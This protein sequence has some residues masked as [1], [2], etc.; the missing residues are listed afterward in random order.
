[1]IYKPDSPKPFRASLQSQAI[2]FPAAVENL[3][4]GRLSEAQAIFRDI[5]SADARHY[6]S[7]HHLGLIEHRIGQNERALDFIR[8][9]LAIKP[10]YAEALSDM[11]LI[12]AQLD[13]NEEAIAA[14]ERAIAANPDY[15]EAH[16]TLGNILLRQGRLAD[17]R[18][19][20]VRAVEL[21]PS[22]AAAYAS[23]ADTLAA[24]G[25][26]EEALLAC[27]RAISLDPRLAI[28]HG[29]KGSILHRR[30]KFAEAA[31]A[32]KRALQINPNFAV[33]HTR[34]ANALRTAGRFEAA[35]TAN[36]RAI[37]LDPAGAE[38]YVN[39]ALT[40]QALGRHVEGQAAYRKAI[41]LKPGYVEAHSG[42]GLLLH[43]IGHTEDAIKAFQAA[44]AID[45]ECDF[46]LTNLASLFKDLGRTGE[47]VAAYRQLLTGKGHVPAASLYD[48]CALR[49]Q[50]CDWEGL[51]TGETKAMETLTRDGERVPPFASLAMQCSPAGHLAL[52]R[53]WARGFAVKPGAGAAQTEPRAAINPE[54]RIRIGYLSSGFCSH[55]TAGLIA[56][57]IERHDRKR[58]EV[59]AYCWSHDDGSDMRQRLTGAFDSFADIRQ[60]SQADSARRIRDDGI[61][62]LIDLKGYTPDARTLILANRP[63]PVQVNFL[64]YPGTMGARFIDYIIADPFVAPMV[65][66]PYF[67]EKIVHLPDCYQ[68]CDTKR[69][70][71]GQPERTGCGL[72]EDGFVFCC[73]G[74][75]SKITGAVFAIWMRLL[76][77]TAGSVL[78]LLDCGETAAANLRREASAHGIG[79]ERLV[80]AQKLPMEE[81][82]A[83]YRLAD[84]LLDTWPFSASASAAEALWCGLPVLTCAGEMFAGRVAGSLLNAARLPELVTSSPADYEALGLRLAS[85]GLMLDEIRDKLAH[86]RTVAPLFAIERYARNIEAAYAHMIWL[87]A[88]G[89]PPE[90]FAVAGLPSAGGAG[91]RGDSLRSSAVR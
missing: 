37:E 62:I 32:Y 47:A 76:E 41:S 45:P 53:S 44:I 21:D 20:Y 22:Y 3:R 13:R 14:C 75:A 28:A 4:A 39:V 86:N 30:G 24:E 67:D 64:G 56:E 73:F 65:H 43:R 5:L 2:G 9:A 69:K 10:D 11:G 74:G 26:L 79:A 48:Y 54:G 1:M 80:F 27:D 36:T 91:A 90:A 84:L 81:H 49:R 46:A 31:D 58:F 8:H 78:W 83:R 51:E 85:E 59:F 34:L 52:A 63:A 33:L 35:L 40:L 42:L 38:G 77:K 71:V 60:F 12:L 88:H 70:I 66:Q 61:D 15:A 87:H 82:L 6:Q 72:P 16:G 55:P 57:L 19:A 29:V 18:S 23:L 7:L 68:P 17:A 89:R 25:R 50:I